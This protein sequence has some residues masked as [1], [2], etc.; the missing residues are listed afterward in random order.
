VFY[1]GWNRS[2]FQNGGSTVIHHPFGDVKKISLD[3]EIPDIPAQPGDVPY[4]GLDDYH[5]FS[6]WWI[7]Y[8][9]VGTTE[10]GSSGCPLFNQAH[11]VIGVLSGGNAACGDSIGY[12]SETDR[13]IY[14]PAP[15]YD[16]YFARFDLAWDYEEAKGNAL[17]PWLDPVNSGDVVLSGYNPSST[18][19][20]Q[21]SSGTRFHVFPNPSRDRF[22]ITP[23]EGIPER[24][25]Y[26]IVNLSGALVESG[27]LD[28]EGRA[29]IQSSG[30][31][32]GIYI[33]KVGVDNY[34]EHHKLLVLDP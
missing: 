6:F 22:Y 30:M 21:I 23:R 19:P 29:E 32:P 7:R 9:D 17:K 27:Q 5:Y 10:G 20:Y 25:F 18:E 3:A 26:A 14:N 4:N 28:S 33:V 1:A 12:D 24:G 2:D 34:Q 16:D 11:R 15:N 13:V 8:W 31:A